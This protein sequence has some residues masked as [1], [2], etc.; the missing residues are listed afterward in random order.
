MTV[1]ELKTWTDYFRLV[2]SGS[3]TFEV[4]KNDRGFESGDILHLKEWRNTSEEYTG[5][6]CFCKVGYVLK[7]GSFG[8]EDGYCVMS[9]RLIDTSFSSQNKKI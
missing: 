4:R 8:I 6:E 7:G 1:H 9:I 2:Q 5:N 3:K